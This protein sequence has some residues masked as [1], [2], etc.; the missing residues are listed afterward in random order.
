MYL[1]LLAEGKKIPNTFVDSSSVAI[2]E[3]EKMSL[4]RRSRQMPTTTTTTTT[5]AAAA[6]A[7]AAAIVNNSMMDSPCYSCTKCGNAYGRLHSLNRHLRFECGVEPKFE[8]PVCH[9]RSK[10]KHNLVL[11]MRTHQKA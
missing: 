6:A 2:D 1:R 10:H 5:A 7:A 8:C 3:S 9:K 11:H 4:T